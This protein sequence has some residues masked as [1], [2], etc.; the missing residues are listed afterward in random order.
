[1]GWLEKETLNEGNE[2]AI[3]PELLS[4]VPEL[5]RS[6]RYLPNGDHGIQ[7]LATFPSLCRFLALLHELTG[8]PAGEYPRVPE[9]P[10]RP[11]H[12]KA[13][14]RSPERGVAGYAETEAFVQGDG[15]GV[16]LHHGERHLLRPSRV[17]VPEH[18]TR[19]PP[20]P[21]LTL[22]ALRKPDAEHG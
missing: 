12:A 2:A 19:H 4:K 18:P 8:N 9:A 5:L 22:G 21:P 16:R 10:S 7:P 17:G 15:S 14:R 20:S 3:R 11:L 13:V 1:M 6:G